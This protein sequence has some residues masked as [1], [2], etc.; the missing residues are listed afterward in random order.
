MKKLLSLLVIMI[1]LA[2]CS[3]MSAKGAVEGYLSKY[4]TLDSEVLVSLDEVV[5]NESFSNQNKDT[6]KEILKKQYKDI[7]YEIIDERYDGDTAYITVKISVYDLYSAEKDAN[8]YL[9]EHEDEFKSD[10][11]Y[12]YDK[13]IEYK[14]GKMK[15]VTNKV[16]Y[17]VIFTVNKEDNKYIVLQPTDNDLLKIH[18]IYN[19]DLS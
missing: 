1:S 5:D 6:Y 2:G 7:S 17:S 16:E 14:L 3:N 18:G 10:G 15:E 8:D 19:Y 9:L 13:F 11:T 12:D 4:K